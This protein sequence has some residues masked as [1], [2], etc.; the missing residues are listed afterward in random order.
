MKSNCSWLNTKQKSQQEVKQIIIKNVDMK[1][2][3]EEKILSILI[4]LCL[5]TISISGCKNREIAYD[6]SGVFEA[7]ETIIAAQANGTLQSFNIEEGEMLDSGQLVGYVDS[8]RLNLKKLQL[9]AQIKATLGQKPDVYKQIAGLQAKLKHAIHE[10]KRIAN[11]VKSDAATQKQLD[12]ANAQID[13]LKKQI[14]AQ[15]S[16]L[17]I[18][19]SGINKAVLPLHIQI[20]TINDQLEKC[21]IIN[22]VKG[23]V[24]T[25]F[26]E[27]YEFTSMGK[28][29]YSIAD[30][31]TMTLRAYITGDQ[32]TVIR[33]GQKVK[34]LT[35]D[36]NE[37]MKQYNG[38]IEWIGTEAEFTPKTVQSKDERANLVYPIKVNVK[39]DGRL[40]IGMYGEVKF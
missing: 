30:L 26:A 6:A 23:T 9:M 1:K 20:E 13:I 3:N 2:I 10:Q 21:K 29:L 27:A 38:T 31:S 8:T 40:K 5:I 39:N 36:K 34:V 32:L 14:A 16:A 37:K 15:Q 35:D 33:L 11:L 12:D 7:T 19:S 28:P 25:K 4:I 18:T 17:D 22:P 24:L